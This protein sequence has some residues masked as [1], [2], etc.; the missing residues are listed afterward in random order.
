MSRI[1][2][3]SIIIPKDTEVKQE[4][5]TIVVKGPKGELSRIFRT[6]VGIK[7]NDG[8]INL[9]PTNNSKFANSLWG[10]YN[11]HLQNMILGVNTP[12]EKKLVIEGVGYRAEMSGNKM[13]LSLGF[14]H[15]IE[16]DIP[17]D[18]EVDIKKNV[19]TITGIDKENV[20]QFAAKVRSYRK[21]EP[22]KGKG[23]RYEDEVVRRK[24]G[25][26]TV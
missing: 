7:I 23:V 13:I 10:T 14:S 8:E 19:I 5:S 11:S 24:E 18:M 3:K 9:L 26:K 4:G 20:G 15:K 17:E 6:E 21:P 25:K 16:L 2:K 22:Y 12:F 1:G